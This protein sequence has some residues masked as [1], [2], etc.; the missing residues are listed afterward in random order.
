[1]PFDPWAA[2]IAVSI[3]LAVVALVVGLMFH[4]SPAVLLFALLLCLAAVLISP[5][6][7]H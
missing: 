6:P 3:L 1:M 4:T 5:L 7:P 2:Q